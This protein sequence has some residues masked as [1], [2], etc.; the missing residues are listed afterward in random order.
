MYMRGNFIREEADSFKDA[1]RDHNDSSKA[2]PKSMS[3]L[4]QMYHK[5]REEY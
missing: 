1:R 3:E 5:L 4:R 2:E